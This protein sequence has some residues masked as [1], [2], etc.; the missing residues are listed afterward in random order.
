MLITGLAG[1][2]AGAGSMALGEW[3]S[4]QSSRELYQR[5]IAIEEQ[6]LAEIPDEEMEELALIYTAKGLAPDQARAA[7]VISA[8]QYFRSTRLGMLPTVLKSCIVW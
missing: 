2:L 1:L 5:Q 4:V 7:S 8:G 3:I 6:E